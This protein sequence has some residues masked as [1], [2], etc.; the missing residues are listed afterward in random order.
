MKFFIY[1][2]S[3]IIIPFVKLYWFIFKPN[4]YGVKCVIE[5]NGKILLVRHSYGKHA[6]SFP[7]GGIKKGEK[8]EVAAKREIAE[9]LG[10]NLYEIQYLGNFLN[11][12]DYVNDHVYCF[13][14]E[15]ENEYFVI[16][17]KEILEAEW[18]AMENL[19]NL[20]EKN[21]KL[22]DMWKK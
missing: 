4:I 15:V 7:G 6:W 1:W 2:G 10:I 17:N 14:G 3:K 20:S 16:D 12:S 13:Y 5:F 11:T 18:F 21:S 9:E 19:P 22:L 8:P